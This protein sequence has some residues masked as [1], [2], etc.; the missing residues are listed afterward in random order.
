[1][2]KP[3]AFNGGRTAF[4]K[5][6]DGRRERPHPKWPI[7]RAF[8]AALARNRGKARALSDVAALSNRWKAW[9]RGEPARV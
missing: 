2:G 4:G 5:R 1:M 7:H 9:L 8:S 6:A 3:A